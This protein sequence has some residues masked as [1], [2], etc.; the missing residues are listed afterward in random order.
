MDTYQIKFQ[1]KE[2]AGRVIQFHHICFFLGAEV[3][4]IMI[5]KN[6]DIVGIIIGENEFK[7]AQFADDTT[8]ILDGTLHSLQSALNTLEIF[9]TLS[10]LRMNKDKTKLIWI[11]RKKLAKE[12]L[13]VSENLTWG[14][15]QF[16][17]LGL[18]FSTSL[19]KIPFLNYGKAM[20]KIKREIE[21]WN[22]RH[23][24][25]FGKITM[26]KKTFYQ[27]VFTYYR[28][29]KGLKHF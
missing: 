10:G 13:N 11:G 14:E 2:A 21:K 20:T 29:L 9:G 12:K 15:T 24:T 25:P 22:K 8:L 5:L 26:L 18:E 28:Q 7:L 4:S 19:E 3:L 27:N 23:L 6:P 17:L 1:S 16:S